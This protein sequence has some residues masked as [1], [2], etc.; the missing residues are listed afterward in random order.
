M[1]NS[2]MM[3]STAGATKSQA[4]NCSPCHV[5]P[6]ARLPIDPSPQPAACGPFAGRRI[7]FVTCA[8]SRCHVR[9]TNEGCNDPSPSH[10]PPQNSGAWRRLGACTVH[11]AGERA[12]AH[13]LCQ[14]LRRRVGD[15][16][17]EGVLRSVH[18]QD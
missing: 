12:S 15:L 6:A 16:L 5:P 2:T 17:E 9:L 4:V 3:V 1:M 10:V 18:R 7:D 14:F 8:T 13:P 11:P